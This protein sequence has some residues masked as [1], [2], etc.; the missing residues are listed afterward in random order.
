MT[1]IYLVVVTTWN[2]F[3]MHWMGINISEVSL[4]LT[5]SHWTRHTVLTKVQIA[6]LCKQRISTFS[7]NFILEYFQAVVLVFLLME[8]M[9]FREL[10][11]WAFLHLTFLHVNTL[12]QTL[13]KQSRIKGSVTHWI[14]IHFGPQTFDSGPANFWLRPSLGLTWS[15]RAPVVL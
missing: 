3:L 6:I 5:N 13:N 2:K 1:L 8:K 10:K 7:T 14:H 9:W 15:P 11:Q 4:I 12:K